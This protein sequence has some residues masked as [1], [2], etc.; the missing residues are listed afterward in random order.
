MARERDIPEMLGDKPFVI[1]HLMCD[2]KPC[3]NPSHLVG[4]T[5][6]ENVMDIWLVH[7]PYDV[8]MEQEAIAE[9]MEHPFVGYFHEASVI[10]DPPLLERSKEHRS[11][12]AY[13]GLQSLCSQ[14]HLH[15]SVPDSKSPDC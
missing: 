11:V 2:N 13:T 8:A 14:S 4:G 3:V 1:R 7:K 15:I 9:Y 10:S 12:Y 5:Q 6:G